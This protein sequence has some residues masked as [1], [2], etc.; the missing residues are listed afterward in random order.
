MTPK[1]HRPVEVRMEKLP[2]VKTI[3]LGQKHLPCW[4]VLEMGAG[5]I[6][7]QSSG[8]LLFHVERLLQ[9]I[10]C[11]ISQD[12]MVRDYISFAH[13]VTLVCLRD[14]PQWLWHVLSV[15]VCQTVIRIQSRNNL[16]FH[17]PGDPSVKSDVCMKITFTAFPNLSCYD[18]SK[19]IFGSGWSTFSLM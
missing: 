12:Y 2:G 19:A 17:Y 6:Y 15:S 7:H 14:N 1:W 10:S 3:Q 5:K 16:S 18:N 8:I 13:I 9:K 11:W 4:V